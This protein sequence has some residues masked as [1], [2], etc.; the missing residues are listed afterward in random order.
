MKSPKKR[1]TVRASSKRYHNLPAVTSSMGCNRYSNDVATPKLPPPPRMAQ[2]RSGCSFALVTTVRP[3]A[4]TSSADKRVSHVAPCLPESQPRPP[5][6][7]RPETPTDAHCPRTG[8]K[9]CGLAAATSSC[10]TTPA[11]AR[12]VRLTGSMMMSFIGDVSITLPREARIGS[13]PGHH[14]GP[15]GSRR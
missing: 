11:P 10:A 13:R 1:S 2:N 5:P 3:S 12:A 15:S 9:P 7:V 4:V 14:P 6:R 8:A